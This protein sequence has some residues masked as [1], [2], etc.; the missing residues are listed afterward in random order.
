MMTVMLLD[1]EIRQLRALQAVAAEGSFGRAAERL[2]FTQSAI[3]QQI[4]SLE[5]AVGDRVFDRPGGPRRVELT[6]IGELVLA[7][8]EAILGQIREAE[9]GLRSMRAGEIGRLMVGSFQ[10]VSVRLLPDVI[11]RLRGERPGLAVRCVESDDP[12]E[13]IGRL[14]D[15]EL[16]LTFLVGM[17]DHDGVS[18]VQLMVDPYVLVAPAGTPDRVVDLARLHRVPM[19]GQSAGF[20]QAKIDDCLRSEGIEPDYVFRTNDNTAVQAMVRAGMGSAIMPLLAVDV[21]D[22]GV[23]IAAMNPPVPPRVLSLARRKGRTLVQAADRFIELAVGVC[24]ELPVLEAQL[25]GL[26]AASGA[27]PNR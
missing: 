17:P 2:G 1:V 8:A 23:V 10:S 22:P 25:V 15:D 12:D 16:D 11:G 13:L 3:S 27:S 21:H 14:L 4:A 6:P 5:R 24:A 7:H 18:A 26:S 9:D 20:C 19:I